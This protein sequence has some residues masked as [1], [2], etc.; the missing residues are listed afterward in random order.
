M[1]YAA[2][3]YRVGLRVI[4]AHEG[5]YYH[6]TTVPLMRFDKCPSPYTRVKLDD[7]RNVKIVS[8]QVAVVESE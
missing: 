2:T 6:G 8:K 4:V 7:G 1:E 5:L 3:N